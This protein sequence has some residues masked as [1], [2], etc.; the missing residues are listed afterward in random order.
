MAFDLGELLKDVSNSGT[1]REQI[2]YIRLDLIEEDPN[3]FYQLSGIEELAA[4]IELCGLQQPVRVRAIPGSDRYRI[5]SGHRRRKAVEA[6]AQDDPERWGEIPCII[7]ADDASPALQ[8][9]R[10]IY[11]NANTRTMTSAEVSEQAVQVEKL[12]YQLKEDGYEFPGR[13]RDHVAQAVGASKSKLARLKVIRDNLAAVWQPSWK[14]GDL[15]E[16]VAYELA[17]MKKPYQTLLFDERDRANKQVRFLG[18]ESVKTF[19]GRVSAI[20][21]QACRAFGG[22]CSNFECKMRKVAVSEYYHCTNCD[23]KCCKDCPDLTSC[24]NACA[25]LRDVIAAK[26]ADKKELARQAKLATERANAPAVAKISALWQRFGLLREMAYKDIDAVKKALGLYYFPYDEEKIMKLECGEAKI[27]PETKLP[28]G[29]SCYLSEIARLIAL[30]D[31]FGCSLDYMFCRTDVKEMA[32]EMAVP[33]SDSD[34]AAGPACVWYPASVTPPVGVKLALL[35]YHDGTDEGVYRGSG[36]WSGRIDEEEPIRAWSLIPS[37]KD[38]E[39]A[40]AA[41]CGAATLWRSGDPETCGTYVAYIQLPGAKKM[42]RE[43]VWTGDAWLLL[44]NKI[45]DGTTV[46]CWAERPKV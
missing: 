40:P 25:K 17:K 34:S 39:A 5:V 20:E 19:A 37:D 3:N 6:L 42:L 38:L 45:D 41:A 16:S 31:L 30:A 14:S 32:Q 24:K 28:F 33:E 18:A 36:L 10:L 2:E 9:L 35:D 43:L 8:Q 21:K 13:M 46:C 11:A 27:S 7:E 26:K 29:Y 22:D 4:N 1:G 12:L 44:G 15:S 23:K